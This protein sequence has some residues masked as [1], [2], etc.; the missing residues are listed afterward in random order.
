MD[1]SSLYQKLRNVRVGNPLC[2]FTKQKCEELIP[3]I[4]RIE[5]LKRDKNAIILAHNYVAPEILFGVADHGV[6]LGHGP[7]RDA[8]LAVVGRHRCAAGVRN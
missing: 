5:E 1:A 4:Q 6:D 3:L 2:S 7:A 8:F